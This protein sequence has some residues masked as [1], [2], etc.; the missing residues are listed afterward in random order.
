MMTMTSSVSKEPDSDGVSTNSSEIV[1]KRRHDIRDIVVQ[2]ERVAS[3]QV[4]WAQ[5]L[6]EL[7]WKL[8]VSLCVLQ[9][10]NL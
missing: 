6:E 4:G 10:V 5:V 2:H 7:Q 8:K 3:V 9:I 1:V